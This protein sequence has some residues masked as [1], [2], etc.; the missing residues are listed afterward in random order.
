M[1]YAALVISLM[2]YS[3][4]R[5]SFTFLPLTLLLLIIEGPYLLRVHPLMLLLFILRGELRTCLCD[6][7]C[8][9]LGV[10]GDAGRVRGLALDATLEVPIL[11][12]HVE[13]CH[14]GRMGRVCGLGVTLGGA[15]VL[16]RLDVELENCACVMLHLELLS[17]GLPESQEGL[18]R[19]IQRSI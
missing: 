12:R 6:I 18:R 11:L 13:G 7:A 19:L 17:N 10:Y 1:D 2:E 8:P 9:A 5:V 15:W 16:A 4:V 14:G 3:I